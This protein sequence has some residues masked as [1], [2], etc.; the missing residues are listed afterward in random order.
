MA[1]DTFDARSGRAQP[2]VLLI[3]D[4]RNLL[5]ALSATLGRAGFS[6]RAAS[7]GR[8]GIRVAEDTCPDL[9]ICDI[10]MPPPDGLQIRNLLSQDPQ[11]AAIPF[12]FLTARASLADRIAGLN[13]GAD[14][15]VTKPFD[16]SEL[17]ARARALMRR[18]RVSQQAGLQ[19]ADS[20]LQQMSDDLTEAY[21]STLLGWSRA[22]EL[23][24]HE[25]A[26]HSQRV[27]ELTVELARAM[28]HAEEA[29]VHIHRGALLH[30]IG[31]MGVPDSILLKPGPLTADEWAVLRQH[32]V[33]ACSFLSRLKYMEPALDI[34]FC[35]HERWDGSGYP[36]QLAGE[37]I[38]EAARIF[39][40]VDVW[41]ALSFDRPYRA[42]WPQ[43][44]VFEYLQD[45]VGRH[46]DPRVVEAFASL[47]AARPDLVATERLATRP[48]EPCG[49][50]DGA[51]PPCAGL[52]P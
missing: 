32:P 21:T 23:R 43:D 52:A 12:I 41:D 15:Y 28:G 26:G 1:Q 45:E 4:D 22:L 5:R 11:L 33:Y 38:P 8:E 14:D 37:S 50:V 9:I 2:S 29:L 16:P 47:R 39:A 17:L 25:T 24:E 19:L 46:F 18:N 34:P 10:M 49:D 35:H 27:A 6:V 7:T 44:A 31:K 42:A 3:D 51:P 40:V 20:L 13:L 36:R 30:D 48:E